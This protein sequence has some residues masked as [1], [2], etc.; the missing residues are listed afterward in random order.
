LIDVGWHVYKQYDPDFVPTLFLIESTGKII[1]RVVA[2]DK[3]GLNRISQTI[4]ARLDVSMEIIAPEQD[5]NP[6]F[7]P[8]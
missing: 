7:K 6:P 2:F 8:G 5:G 3:A 1:D 4:A